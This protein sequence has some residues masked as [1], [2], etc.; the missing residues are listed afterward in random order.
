MPESKEAFE[1][2]T[3]SPENSSR[4]QCK[5]SDRVNGNLLSLAALMCGIWLILLSGSVSFGQIM[6]H[7]PQLKI[8]KIKGRVTTNDE[9]HYPISS[10]KVELF[11]LGKNKAP[12]KSALTNQDGFFEIADAAPGEYRL[13]VWATTEKGFTLFKSDVILKLRKHGGKKSGIK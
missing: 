5:L 6:C 2:L 4:K 10:T 8:S 1:N 3:C 12:I 13:A 11:G 9:S 7:L